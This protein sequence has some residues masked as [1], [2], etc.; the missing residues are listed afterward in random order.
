MEERGALPDG[1]ASRR[2]RALLAAAW[3]AALARCAVRPGRE[4]QALTARTVE[5]PPRQFWALEV[6]R[7]AR[8]VEATRAIAVSA[9]QWHVN[10][11]GALY[12]DHWGWCEDFRILPAAA[13]GYL[14][15]TTLFAGAMSGGYSQLSILPALPASVTAFG[16][17]LRVAERT[18]R[19]VLDV[20]GQVTEL[21]ARVTVP[22]GNER[23]LVEPPQDTGHFEPGFDAPVLADVVYRAVSY[24]RLDSR[25]I[26]GRAG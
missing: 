21:P 25:R 26:A 24:G 11:I 3:P 14:V 17:L 10:G 6:V 5:G 16:L 12:G 20:D 23:T 22:L 13:A 8:P 2:R 19:L 7:E 15:A 9:C 1:H 18:G 4:Q